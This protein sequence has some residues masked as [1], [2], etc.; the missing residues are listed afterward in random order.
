[1]WTYYSAL[2][3]G[4]EVHWDLKNGKKKPTLS[5]SFLSLFAGSLF[6]MNALPCEKMSGKTSGIN[7]TNPR[8]WVTT[9]LL[10]QTVTICQNC[11]QMSKLAHKLFTI[12]IIAPKQPTIHYSNHRCWKGLWQGEAVLSLHSPQTL[13]IFCQVS[14]IGSTNL[15]TASVMTNGVTSQ[16]FWLQRDEARMEGRQRCPLSLPVHTLGTPCKT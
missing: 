3:R 12:I 2:C 4:E 5:L 9:T 13:W 8:R 10:L 11:G 14:P 7:F 6:I 16:P 15:A 1:M